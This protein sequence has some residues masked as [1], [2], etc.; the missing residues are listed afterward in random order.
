MSNSIKDIFYHLYKLFDFIRDVL[1]RISWKITDSFL[2]NPYDHI[3]YVN[4]YQSYCQMNSFIPNRLENKLINTHKLIGGHTPENAHM[5]SIMV[6]QL[7][8]D[9]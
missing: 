8:K 3:L 9:I 4:F 1:I 7:K 5:A 6:E 2:F